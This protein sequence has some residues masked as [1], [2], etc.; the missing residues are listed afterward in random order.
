MR[1]CLLTGHLGD[2]LQT[3]DRQSHDDAQAGA[4]HQQ[5]VA[6]EQAGHGQP[7]V[8]CADRRRGWSLSGHTGPGAQRPGCKH[9]RPGPRVLLPPAS[10]P[11]SGVTEALPTSCT[12]RAGRESGRCARDSFPRPP[13]PALQRRTACAD[14]LCDRS[15]VVG[16]A[17]SPE[18]HTRHTR[19]HTNARIL[20]HTSMQMCAHTRAQAQMCVHTSTLMHACTH[21]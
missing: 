11:G 8:P 1:T 13:R 14:R 4:D 7:L 19:A 12:P 21:T 6:D 10:P 5:A 16:A 15:A 2:A 18:A 9:D 3:G 17:Q 20:V